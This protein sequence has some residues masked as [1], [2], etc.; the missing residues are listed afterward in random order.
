MKVRLAGVFYFY[1]VIFMKKLFGA[2]RLLDYVI[3][4]T[5]LAVIAVSFFATKGSEYLS[6]AASLI[7]A[8]ALIFTAKGN[9]VGQVLMIVFGIIYAIISYGFAYYGEMITYAGMS[10]PMAVFSLISWL[11]HPFNGN[12]SHVKINDKISG[13]EMIF[14]FCLTAAVTFAFYFILSALGTASIVTS[15]VSVATSF[16]SV[17]FTFRR[18]PLHSL[19][20]ASNDVVLIILWALACA[21]DP[22]QIAVIV[23]FCVFLLNDVYGYINWIKTAKKQKVAAITPQPAAE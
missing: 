16:I 15:T 5:S 14:A 11:T 21:K 2:F 22:S 4:F 7:G 17:Y 1:E 20:Y 23:C 12:R 9:P 8:T 3:W 19:F 13:K 6:L 10:V 18:S